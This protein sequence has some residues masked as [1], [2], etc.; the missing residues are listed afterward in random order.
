[1]NLREV[2]S[3]QTPSSGVWLVLSWGS[4]AKIG[5]N[6]SPGQLA[7]RLHAAGDCEGAGHTL[8][9]LPEEKGQG[10]PLVTAYLPGLARLP[11]VS[12]P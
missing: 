2:G 1:M 3:E 7:P 12:P 11:P 5:L 6:R 4:G 10:K 9:P 8:T